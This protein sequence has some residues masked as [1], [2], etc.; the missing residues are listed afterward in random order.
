MSMFEEA[1]REMWWDGWQARCRK[2]C[3][4]ENERLEKYLTDYPLLASA[5]EIAAERDRLREINRDVRELCKIIV[6]SCRR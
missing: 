2:N 6:S 1:L 4:L 3:S 5:P